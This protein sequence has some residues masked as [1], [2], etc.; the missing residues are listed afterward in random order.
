ME[1]QLRYLRCAPRR[2]PPHRPAAVLRIHRRDG[3]KRNRRNANR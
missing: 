1:W 2:N 3:A